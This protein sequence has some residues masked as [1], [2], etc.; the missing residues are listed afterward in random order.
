MFLGGLTMEALADI[1]RLLVTQSWQLAILIVLVALASYVLRNRSAHIRYFFWLIVLAKCLV[2]PLL[3]VPLAIL[4]ETRPV[5]VGSRPF[6]PPL[7]DE[8]PSVAPTTATVSEDN[9]ATQLVPPVIARNRFTPRLTVYE[10]IGLSWGLGVAVYAIIIL[11]QALWTYLWIRTRRRELPADLERQTNQVFSGVGTATYPKVWLLEGE[12]QPFVWGLLR[13][14][15]YLPTRFAKREDKRHLRDILVHEVSHTRRFDA[16]VNLLQIMAQGIFWFHP[17]VWWANHRIRI[18]R[19][20][21]CDEMA[22]ALLNTQAKE[23]SRAI[24]DVIATEYES[25]RPISA[26]AIIGPARSIEERIRAMM[27]PGKKFHKHPSLIAATVAVLIA[28][29]VV[30]TAFVLTARAQAEISS[31]TPAAS[32]EETP[33]SLHAAIKAGDLAEVKRLIAQ[34]VDVNASEGDGTWTPLAEAAYRGHSE[35]VKVLLSNGAEVDKADG[36]YTP[37]YYAIWSDDNATVKALIE[38]GTNVNILPHEKDY[39]PVAY[40]IWQAHVDNV[41]T[42]LDAGATLDRKDR[43]G[44]TPLY[45]AAFSSSKEVFDLILARGNYD[46]TV[47]LAARRGELEKVKAFIEDGA[48]VNAKDAF[49]CTLLH[50]AVLA[51]SP[52]VAEFLIAKEADLN[53][54]DNTGSTALAVANGLTMVKLL[55]S[56]GADIDARVQL[57]GYTRLHISCFAGERDVVQF[58]IGEGADIYAIDNAGREPLHRAAAGGH[59]DI[60]GL[61]IAKGADLNLRARNGATP[62]WEAAIYGRADMVK[63]LLAKEADISA[64]N[65]RGQTPLAAAKQRGHTE[66]VSILRQ[67]GAKVTLHGAVAV[68]DIEEVKR[69]ITEGADV[70]V[71]NEANQTPLHI[72]ASR[73]FKDVAE[74]L[75]A[76]GAIVNVRGNSN[77]PLHLAARNGRTAL[78]ELLL[79]K[80]ADINANDNQGYTPLGRAMEG[81]HS[82]V[83]ALLREHGAKESL[84]DVVIAG[85][86][87]AVKRFLSEGCDVNSRDSL[88]LTPLHLAAMHGH[89]DIM[90]LLIAKGADLEARDQHWGNT[91]LLHATPY[92]RTEAVRLLLEK[93]ANIEARDGH[94]LTPLCL[95]S[96]YGTAIHTKLIQLLLDRG[97]NIESH[98]YGGATPLMGA[99]SV[100]RKEVAKM[101]LARG[102]TLNVIS[103]FYGTAAHLAMLVGRP[104]MVR[105]S[106]KKG[107][108]IPPLH[109]AAYLGDMDKVRSLVD[110]GAD[111]NQKDVA[112]F[113]PLHCTVLGN[114]SEIMQFLIDTGAD[115]EARNCAHRTPLFCASERGYLEMVRLL[116]TNGANVNARGF[117]KSMGGHDF[118]DDWTPLHIAAQ[119]GHTTVVQYLINKGASNQAQCHWLDDEGFTPLHLAAWMGRD[120]TVKVLLAKGADPNCKT[121]KGQTPLGSARERN[122]TTTIQLLREHGAKD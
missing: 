92:G 121:K 119:M 70:N 29:L 116:L 82:K 111:V 22:I 107:I 21:C 60:A 105:W 20:K 30:P 68:G 93:G 65:R 81:K 87:D 51:D 35:I 64:P 74:L 99:I 113:T 12:A 8:F 115:I 23:Y 32:E 110:G 88:G 83:I 13:G 15:V 102:A 96:T 26:L 40:A 100:G 109:V 44:C 58:L 73:G 72:A 114:N 59:V 79:N 31:E 28:L 53:V 76:K 86:I 67:H 97:A 7:E 62:L 38:A 57:R 80:G 25:T 90:E 19:E 6:A 106:I 63:F 75:I 2:P 17:F 120:D 71:K 41:K 27:T 14:S 3:T 1:A 36:Y 54:K 42:L 47:Y 10:W 69:L 103:R 52:E 46:D 89:T 48:N 117:R 33:R 37:L 43:D 45:W 50:W 94:G 91:P 55:V 16:A 5:E 122:Q 61:L 18:E 11:A 39:P 49:G 4:P 78:V 95:S 104:D 84:H 101:L 66:V 9:Q 112:Q 24:V 56:K 118:A 34:G 98:S 108:A 77:T 85:D